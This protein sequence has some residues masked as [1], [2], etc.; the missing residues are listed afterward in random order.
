MTHMNPVGYQSTNWLFLLVFMVATAAFTP[1][2]ATSPLYIMQHSMYMP[3]LG[4][5]FAIIEAGSNEELVIS[6]TESCSW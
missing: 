5:H 6:A 1:F 2:G 3:C 4:S